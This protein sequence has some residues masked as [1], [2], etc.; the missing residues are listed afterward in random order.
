M[1]VRFR[2]SAHRL[3]VSLVETR[4]LAGRV[5]HDHVASLGSIAVPPSLANRI[6]YWERLHQRLATLSNRLDPETQGKTLGTVHAR[7]AM[8]TLEE[9]RSLQIE[10][11]DADERLWSAVEGMHQ[12]TIEERKAL[13]ATTERAIAAGQVEAIQA[14]QRAAAARDRVARLKAGEDVVEA[15]TRPLTRK[16]VVA[17]LGWTPSEVRHAERVNELYAIG[18]ENEFLAEIGDRRRINRIEQAASRRVLRRH[19]QEEGKP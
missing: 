17:A 2:Q 8:P 6:A 1:F 4:R 18:A 16:D 12:S 7:I 19:R 13:I 9:R 5:H 15:G 10:N 11:A 14:A 3:Q